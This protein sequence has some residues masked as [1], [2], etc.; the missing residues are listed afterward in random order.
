MEVFVV[1]KEIAC[2]YEGQKERQ[3]VYAGTNESW[4]R[5]VAQLTKSPYTKYIMETWENDDWVCE[6]SF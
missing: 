4:A 3:V 6:E 1:L 5:E 2:G